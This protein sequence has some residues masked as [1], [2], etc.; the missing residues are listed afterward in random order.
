M[1]GGFKISAMLA[2]LRAT[3]VDSTKRLG[4][5]VAPTIVSSTVLSFFFQNSAARSI[6]Y[7]SC[8]F[9]IFYYNINQNSAFSAYLLP[10][11]GYTLFGNSNGGPSY[12]TFIGLNN[13]TTANHNY[14]DFNMTVT[15][16]SIIPRTFNLGNF[17]SYWL[18]VRIPVSRTVF[19]VVCGD[20]YIDPLEECDD[21]NMI[22]GDGCF[23]NC[24]I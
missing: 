21:G 1:A 2:G 20:G 15:N 11:I 16:S 4:M 13:F 7:L 12:Q 22:N 9:V 24:T 17:M 14:L 3:L 10:F 5:Q 19:P 18:S 6:N 23:S 8:S